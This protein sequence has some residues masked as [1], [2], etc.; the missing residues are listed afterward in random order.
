MRKMRVMTTRLL[1]LMTALLICLTAKLSACAEVIVTNQDTGYQVCIEDDAELLTEEERSELARQMLGITDYGNVMF[2]TIDENSGSTSGYATAF[3]REC[4]GSSSGTVFL[5]DMDNR[6]IWIRNDGRISQI[7]TDDYSDTVT[8]NCYSYASRGDYYG[9][10]QKAY[11]QI[12]ALLRGQ[13]IAQPMKYI[14][15]A[16]MAVILSLLLTLGLVRLVSRK[17]VPGHGDLLRAVSHEFRLNDPLATYTGTTKEYDP[18]SSDSSDS[19][20]SGGGSSG[21]GSGGGHSF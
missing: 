10:A 19:G 4:F 7:V 18:P 14:C 15:N 13:R 2:K 21:S 5:I 16:F 1:G 17:T 12:E 11:S 8:D 6:N 20:G 9:C 3:Y